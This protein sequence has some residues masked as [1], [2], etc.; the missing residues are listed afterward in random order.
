MFI[1]KRTNLISPIISVM[2]MLRSCVLSLLMFLPITW[3]SQRIGGRCETRGGSHGSERRPWFPLVILK[4]FIPVEGFRL[5]DGLV[6]SH[7]MSSIDWNY[8]ETRCENLQRLGTQ[9]CEF[10]IKYL[11][12]SFSCEYYIL[13]II[14]HIS[15]VTFATTANFTNFNAFLRRCRWCRSECTS[16]RHINNIMT[17]NRVWILLKR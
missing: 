7:E 12:G 17:Q 8:D 3:T 2:M 13:Y 4:Y 11:I 9:F 14:I 16:P 10:H 5:R 1:L 6:D 15:I